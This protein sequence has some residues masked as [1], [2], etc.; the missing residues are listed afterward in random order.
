SADMLPYFNSPLLNSI[1]QGI[2]RGHVTRIGGFGG[3][4]KS[5][6]VVEKF[7]MSC[8]ANQERAIVILNEEDAQALRQ[9]VV[10]SILYH[11]FHIGMDRRTMGNGKLQKLDKEKIRQAFARMRDLMHG[12]EAQIK[13][14]FME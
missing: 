10:L 7:I 3:K 11:E 12:E 2:P 1:S 6:I 8:I 9:K 5:A 13:V 14:T 4:G